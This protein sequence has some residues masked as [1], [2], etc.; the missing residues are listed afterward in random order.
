MTLDI[1]GV[2]FRLLLGFE[3]IWK[4]QIPKLL[5]LKFSGE[6]FVH[7]PLRVLG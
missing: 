3:H 1:E 7:P 5:S 2:G 4:F 6:K